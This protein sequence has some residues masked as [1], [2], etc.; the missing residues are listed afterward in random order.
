MLRRLS[1]RLTYFLYCRLTT[2]APDWVA[3]TLEGQSRPR[4]HNCRRILR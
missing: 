3:M 1:N 4:C 2:C